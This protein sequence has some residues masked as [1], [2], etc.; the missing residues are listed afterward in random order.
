MLATV[1]FV[2]AVAI[3]VYRARAEDLLRCRITKLSAADFCEK[4]YETQNY[5]RQDS[6][7]LK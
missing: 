1:K 6:I 3:F 2:N 4:F 5:H 7:N